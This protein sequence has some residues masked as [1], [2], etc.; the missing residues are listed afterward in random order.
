MTTMAEQARRLAGAFL[1]LNTWLDDFR[2]L[3]EIQGTWGELLI[4]SILAS[5]EWRE[6]RHAARAYDQAKAALL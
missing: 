6:C 1:D 5:P 2:E 3:P 4:R